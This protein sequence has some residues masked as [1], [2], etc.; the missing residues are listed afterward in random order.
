MSWA[1]LLTMTGARTL[2]RTPLW[3][4]LELG[5]GDL[6]AL[7][8]FGQDVVV[9]F[10]SGLEQLVA[11]SGDLGLQLVRDGDLS[12]HALLE[13]V[14]LAMEEVDEA[15]ERAR[16]ADGQVEGGDL[17]A[18]LGA[19]G[20]QRAH[21][22]GVLALAAGEHEEGRRAKPSTEGDGGL[23]AGLDATGGIHADDGRV[24]G[25]E[26]LDDLAHEVGIAGRVDHRD[27]VP[28]VVEAGDRQRQ[29][30]LPFLFL[31]LEIEG[32]RSRHPPCPGGDGSG[33]S[34]RCSPSVVLPASLCPAR[35]TL[36]RCARST[37]FMGWA[38]LDA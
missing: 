13:P 24:D 2:S 23:G 18:E 9:G 10:G 17:G 33:A 8:V 11:S 27:P 4:G 35:T 16:S 36:R 38:N 28:V 26:A 19:Q 22:V 1:A 32:W 15:A 30:E 29:R 3:A 34:R 6:L 5:V 31:G 12:A 21:R 7:E 20:V 14:G 37:L 25:L